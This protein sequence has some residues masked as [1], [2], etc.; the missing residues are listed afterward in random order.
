MAPMIGGMQTMQIASLTMKGS[1][2]QPVRGAGGA[3]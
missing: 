1:D 3:L 2:F